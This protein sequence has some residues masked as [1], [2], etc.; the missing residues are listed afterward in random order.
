[1]FQSKSD[2]SH[3][4]NSKNV[5]NHVTSSEHK[6]THSAKDKHTHSAKD[7]HTHSAKD[8]HTHSAKDKH[9][10]S[11]KDKHTHSAKDKSI[12]VIHPS[13]PSKDVKKPSSDSAT[14]HISIVI[15]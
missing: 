8:K 6:H 5:D 13:T 4:S 2:T 15:M 7:K 11:A 10:H 14:S 1:M 3:I 12:Q 9:T